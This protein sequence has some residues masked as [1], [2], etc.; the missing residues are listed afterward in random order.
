MVLRNEPEVPPGTQAAINARFIEYRDDRDIRS[1]NHLIEEHLFVARQEANRFR[2]RGEPMADLMQVAQLGLLK[3]VERYDPTFGIPFTAFARPTIAGELRRHFRDSTWTMRVPRRMKDLHVRLGRATS[4]LTQK[5]GR[6]PTASELARELHCTVD[7]VLE[8]LDLASA[9]RPSS[10]SAVP[11]DDDAAAASDPADE[12]ALTQLAAM[13]DRV[14]L[15]QLLVDLPS[16][17]RTVLYLRFFTEMTQ[18][19]IAERVG[20]SQVHVSRLLRAS[21]ARLR[22]H[23]EGQIS[24]ET[25]DSC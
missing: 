3:A 5:L 21:L 20:V 13:A 9:Y 7:E 6:R 19:E 17:E 25:Q 12:S 16:R 4:E 2:G 23:L 24:V 15:H 14:T 10:L 8:S 22:A 11:S 1:R 18:S